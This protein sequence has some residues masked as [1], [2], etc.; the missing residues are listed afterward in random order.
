MNVY[1]DYAATSPIREEVLKKMLP[2][3]REEFGNP[4]SLHACGRRAAYLVTEA[5]DKIAAV[6]GVRAR[7]IYFTS[8]GTEADNWAVRSLAAGAPFAV[9]SIEHA[10]VIEAAKMRGEH[11]L[12]PVDGAGR[13]TLAG[14][15][16]ALE[17]GAKLLALMA[18]NNETGVVQP[19]EAVYRAAHERGAL[20]F[21]DG[22]QAGR[23]CNLKAL[24][25][26]CDALSLSAHKLGGP[27]GTGLLW[28]RSGVK[29][30][31]L[32][33]GGEQERAL[34][35]G[36]LNTAG[37]VGMAEALFLAQKEREEFSAHTRRLRDLF[38]AHI[39]AA[40]GG[41]ARIDGAE[42]ERA[43]NLLHITF[44]RGGEWLLSALDLHGVC[45]SG[46]AACSAHAA[47]PSHVLLAMGRSE[48]EAKRGVRFSFGGE[49]TEKEAVFAAETAVG[50]LRARE[51]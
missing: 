39:L 22:V 46:G 50:L 26:C 32:I 14:A 40:L 45:C 37:I 41:E 8:G 51:E 5:R 12:L 43:P 42:A 20:L 13:A 31:P 3:L 9:S 2:C 33:A 6:L 25:K 28:V 10:A 30:A 48:E 47:R 17:G 19:V 21:C 23:S 15:E 27:K 29:L 35:G 38:E 16:E 1:L 36:T 49:T 11:A 24:T 44:A 34:R 7:E 4:D 18:V